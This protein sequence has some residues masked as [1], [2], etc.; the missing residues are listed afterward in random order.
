MFCV[1][2]KVTPVKPVLCCRN[3]L[4]T[5]PPTLWIHFLQSYR[6]KYILLEYYN[7]S[8]S[9]YTM[10]VVRPESSNFKSKLTLLLVFHFNLFCFPKISSP[11]LHPFT[12]IMFPS[13]GPAFTLCHLTFTFSQE[14]WRILSRSYSSR[15]CGPWIMPVFS[16]MMSPEV[17][18][19][20]HKQ[21]QATLW[22]WE[23]TFLLLLPPCQVHPR[24]LNSHSSPRTAPGLPGKQ[25]QETLMTGKTI[26][27]L[28]RHLEQ[29]PI[30]HLRF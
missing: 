3:S 20:L 18:A 11:V 2:W 8:K 13:Q 28:C 7:L 14:G 15:Q 29:V 24:L 25:A 17:C 22:L 4:Q 19:L 9:Y 26:G 10:K 5:L 1:C 12:H 30:T 6:R 21:V 23:W 16:H 27:P